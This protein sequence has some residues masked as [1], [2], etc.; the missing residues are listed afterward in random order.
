MFIVVEGQEYCMNH[1]KT[2][3]APQGGGDGSQSSTRP[4]VPTSESLSD[5][6]LFQVLSNR[7][8]RY[9]VHALKGADG[10]AKIGD[11]AEQVAAWEYDVDVDQVSYNERKRVYTA[12]QQSHL[13]MMDDVGIVE[14]DKN[15]GVVQPSDALDDIDVYMEIVQG[16]GIPWSVH[17]L[18]LSALAISLMLATI[19][20]AWPVVLLP[21]VAWGVAITVMFTVS[22]IVHT[23]FARG[24]RIGEQEK[25]P[26]LRGD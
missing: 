11:V 3:V 25:P 22:A 13:P 8:R 21:D 18:G 2:L 7:R 12:L 16:N 9:A 15:R 26:E 14:F 23:Y 4:D 5:D 20:G 17:Y 10:P 24:Q 19:V 1:S 6:D